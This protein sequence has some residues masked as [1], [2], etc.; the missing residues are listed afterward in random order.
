MEE[1]KGQSLTEQGR[2]IQW[3]PTSPSWSSSLCLSLATELQLCASG[4]FFA[5]THSKVLACMD[6][7]M[8]MTS[9]RIFINSS[10]RI[11]NWMPQP[12]NLRC[13]VCRSLVVSLTRV[14]LVLFSV[15]TPLRGSKQMQKIIRSCRNVRLK[16]ASMACRSI[17]MG[18]W[19]Y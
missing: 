4:V 8:L 12:G 10:L 15:Q 6:Q 11:L 1:L 5:V 13:L 2:G 3:T 7:C 17:D 16:L 18:L 19:F 9:L 14:H